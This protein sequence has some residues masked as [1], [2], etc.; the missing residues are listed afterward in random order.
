MDGLQTAAKSK[1]N[2]QNRSLCPPVNRYLEES[3]SKLEE[4]GYHFGWNAG[5]LLHFGNLQVLLDMYRQSSS[6][7]Y[8]HPVSSRCLDREP[9]EFLTCMC[10]H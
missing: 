4:N 1:S 8:V 3:D 5:T 2:L 7:P 6:S 10:A 9:Q